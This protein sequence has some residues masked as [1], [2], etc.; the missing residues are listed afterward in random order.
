MKILSLI[1]PTYNM[2]SLLPRC[3]DSLIAPETKDRLEVI[4]V[5]D[6]SGDNSLEIA[7]EYASRHP[8]LIKVFD[9]PNGNYGSTINAVLPHISGDYVKIL[10]SDDWFDPAALTRYLDELDG[11]PQKVDIS[12]SHFRIL[13]ADG[14]RETIKYNVYGREPYEYGK[15]YDLDSVLADGYIRFFLMHFLA[16]RTEMLRSID[17]HQTEGISYTDIEWATFP[18]FH[19]QSIVFHDI[20]LY[21]YVLG[22]EGQ[23]MDPKSISRS[24]SHLEGMTKS[25][26]RYYQKA[27]ITKLSEARKAFLRQYYRNRMRILIKTHLM[28]I[29]REEFD[30]ERFSALDAELQDVRKQ[31]GLEQFRLYPANKIIHIDVYRYWMRHRKRLPAWFEHINS[32]VDRVVT[33]LFVRLFH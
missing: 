32:M 13:H 6:G 20:I 1:I 15:I 14:T 9:K 19:A 4:V 21:Q 28:D 12:V 33:F 24:L 29:P 11:L 2:A 26:V 17:Y 5:N 27:D 30:P 25:L 31:M 8:G 22:R 16:Y 10:D 7:E 23:T 3:L 18:L